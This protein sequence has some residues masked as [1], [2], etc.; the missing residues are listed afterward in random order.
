MAIPVPLTPDWLDRASL[1]ELRAAS[2]AMQQAEREAYARHNDEAAGM[3]GL[4]L[5]DIEVEIRMR[6]DTTTLW[7]MAADI[8]AT[9]ARMVRTGR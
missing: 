7:G 3:Y 9:Q 8:A 5:D 4:A 1:D 2:T 6:S